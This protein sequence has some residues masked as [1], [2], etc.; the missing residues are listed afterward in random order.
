MNLGFRAL[1]VQE[2]SG[3]NSCWMEK[4]VL[5]CEGVGKSYSGVQ[6]LRDVPFALKRAEI[7]ALIGENGAG[8][9]TL[10]KIISGVI[11]P[12]TGSKISINQELLTE[13]TPVLA[14]QKGISVI[15][16]DLSLLANLSVAENLFLGTL[17]KTRTFWIGWEKMYRLATQILQEISLNIHP[18]VLVE[19]LSVGK[20]QMVAIARALAS[21]TKILIMDEPTSALSYS[22]IEDL[23]CIMKRLQSRGISIIFVSHKLDELFRICD[24]FTILRDGEY[25]GTFAKSALSEARL[26]QLMAGRKIE[27]FIYPKRR[28]QNEAV[29][30]E[31]RNL[32]QKNRFADIS[33]CLHRGEILG[34]YGMVG[35]G[36]TE[37]M[38]AIFGLERPDSGQ[39]LLHG[40]PLSIGSSALARKSGLAYIPEDRLGEGLFLERTVHD[41]LVIAAGFMARW[42]LRNPGAE[43]ALVQ[44][45]ID[46][47]HI[48]PQN[49]NRSAGQLSGGNQQKVVIGKW[50]SIQPK[51]IIIDE[52][53]NGIDIAAKV[54]VHRL[55]RAFSDEGVSIILVSS[56]MNEIISVCDR[57]IVMKRGRIAGAL[58]NICQQTIM[59]LSAIGNV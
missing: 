39:I 59:K 49:P 46:A 9:S 58:Q 23:F 40:K 34:F 8:K 21:Q 51:I 11:Q 14:M 1:A 48:V 45:Q 41:N 25:M 54:E 53:T 36:R 27:Y 18:K 35:A 47:L 26:I 42:S 10:T 20:R 33:F 32:C 3:F 15:Y 44:G 24:T 6:A 19:S 43:V 52:P 5:E 12:N 28:R 56:E 37:L 38:Q 4:Y 55:L 13:I 31:A 2:I 30:L 50:L 57:V 7:H 29:V 16:Q 22:E 17:L